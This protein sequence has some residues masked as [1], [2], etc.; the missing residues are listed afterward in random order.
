MTD[1]EFD[2]HVIKYIRR[3]RAQADRLCELVG[4]SGTWS[5][6]PIDQQL[7]RVVAALELQFGLAPESKEAGADLVQWFARGGGISRCG[8]FV[9]AV[10]AAA[11]M[12]LCGGGKPDDFA[13]WPERVA[14]SEAALTADDL[15]F[16]GPPDRE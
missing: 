11:A 10:A 12:E 9:D 2:L 16:D 14:K 5:G 4:E 15:Y 13:I 8:P 7:A 6:E 1:R 3:T